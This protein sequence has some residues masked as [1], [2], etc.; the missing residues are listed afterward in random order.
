MRRILYIP[1]LAI[2]M[3][4]A[5]SEGAAGDVAVSMVEEAEVEDTIS[6][7]ATA[8]LQAA[9]MRMNALAD[10]LALVVDAESAARLAP[11]ITL[12]YGELKDADFAV[13]TDEDEEVVAAEF[14][15]DMFLSL[16]AQLERLMEADFYSNMA[17]KQL[18]GLENE[19]PGNK[20]MPRLEAGDEAPAAESVTESA[21]QP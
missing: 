5:L 20:E 11:Q 1:V 8:A 3:M 21:L 6:Q 4:P 17:L 18:F 9:K 16:D 10:M 12:A 19:E 7:E 14:A 15:E 2:A 13:L